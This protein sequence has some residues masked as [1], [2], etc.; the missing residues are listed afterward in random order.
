MTKFS[1]VPDI[2]AKNAVSTNNKASIP[3]NDSV[4]KASII[5]PVQ[6]IN[7]GANWRYHDTGK[8]V[9]TTWHSADYSNTT[10]KSGSAPLGYG[11]PWIKTTVSFGADENLKYTATYFRHQF[12]IS[13]DQQFTNLEAFIMRDDGV[14]LY[15]N[16]REIARSNM[17]SGPVAFTTL[18][19]SVIGNADE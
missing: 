7:R 10:W 16:G 6:L 19:S 4:T 3:K 15:L 2:P 17:P 12:T 11:D 13:A 1:P 9:A 8:D 14:V 5:K 18:A